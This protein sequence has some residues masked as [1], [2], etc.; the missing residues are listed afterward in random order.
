MVWRNTDRMCIKEKFNIKVDVPFK[1][2]TDNI[3]SENI[4]KAISN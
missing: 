3:T 2:N 4:Q 1:S